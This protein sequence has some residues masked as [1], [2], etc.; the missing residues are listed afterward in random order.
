MSWFKPK[1]RVQ[2]K[3]NEED[4]WITSCARFWLRRSAVK[5]AADGLL[6]MGIPN[7]RVINEDESESTSFWMN[8]ERES[9]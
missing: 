1:Y 8:V 6:K 2:W 5:Y 7:W 3:H 9:S 4:E